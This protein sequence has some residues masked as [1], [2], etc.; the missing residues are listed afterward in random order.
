M[1]SATGPGSAAFVGYY[2][3][4][5]LAKKLMAALGAPAPAASVAVK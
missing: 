5:D 2:D 1:T 3:N 4:T